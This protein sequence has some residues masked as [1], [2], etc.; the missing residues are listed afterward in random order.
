MREPDHPAP[1]A[2]A[3]AHA[4]SLARGAL[5]EVYAGTE[6]DSP[7]LSALAMM[8]GEA[9]TGTDGRVQAGQQA[10][11]WVRHKALGREVG[12]PHPAGLAE[13][14]FDPARLLLLRARDAPSALQ[15]GLEGAR[16]AALAAVIIELRG[17]AKAYDLTASRRLALAAR[18][19]GVPVFMVR[20][21][22]AP[23]PSAAETRWL[24]RAAP[25]RALAAKAPGHPAF[26]LVLLRARNG[27]DGLQHHLEWNRDA[28]RLESR[29][30]GHGE[31]APAH[32]P[33]GEP[34]APLSRA[35][36]AIPVHRPGPARHEPPPHRRAG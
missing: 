30:P 10:T 15:A 5:H 17:E 19:S 1:G 27:Q 33:G 6:A 29:L 22:A 36:V 16:C 7:S 4:F 23:M 31:T 21:A 12:E 3:L 14:G 34:A 18:A 9:S 13:L 25:S 32:Q 20:A 8:L 2:Q 26:H 28:Q 11:L 24:A 35:V